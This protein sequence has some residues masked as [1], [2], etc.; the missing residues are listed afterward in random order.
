MM[1]AEDY[2]TDFF[3]PP[4]EDDGAIDWDV[5]DQMVGRYGH[6]IGRRKMPKSVAAT[7][8]D[9]TSNTRRKQQVDDKIQ[10]NKFYVGSPRALDNNWGHPTLAKAIRHAEEVMEDQDMESTFIVQIIRVVRR[11]RMPAEVTKV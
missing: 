3:D 9:I 5:Y 11:K 1:A 4:E 10:R 8:R 7:Q 6:P 2:H